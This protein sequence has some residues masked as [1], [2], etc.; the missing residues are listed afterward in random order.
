MRALGVDNS[1]APPTSPATAGKYSV[2][3]VTF[4]KY[5]TCPTRIAG[6]SLHYMYISRGKSG[7]TWGDTGGQPEE[8]AEEIGIVGSRKLNRGAIMIS[9]ATMRNLGA[10]G[11]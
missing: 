10:D 1:P 7:I 9:S 11:I 3:L 5:G 6:Q 8:R 4:D 2:R